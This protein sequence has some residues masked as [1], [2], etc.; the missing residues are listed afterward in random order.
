MGYLVAAVVSV[1]LLCVLNLVVS[2][3]VVRRLRRHTERLDQLSLPAAPTLGL[4]PGEVVGEFATTTTD[5]QVVESRELLAERVL[6][7][8]FSPGCPPCAEQLPHF[9][10]RARSLPGGRQRVLAVLDAV[11]P[12]E[13][14]IS[15]VERLREHALVVTEPPEGPVHA[16]LQVTAF[17][18]FFV[19]EAGG[20]VVG[21]GHALSELGD[22]ATAAELTAA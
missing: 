1:G 13:P 4:P 2:I 8:F 20:M 19:V 16:A 14:E 5:G 15:Y 7:G 9:L 22:L 3:G 10:E 12:D 18:T 21:R 6:V 11:V 17:P